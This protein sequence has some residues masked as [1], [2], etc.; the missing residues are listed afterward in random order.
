M[1]NC[2]VRKHT[3]MHCLEIGNGF[4]V[5]GSGDL[6]EGKNTTRENTSGMHK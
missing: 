3:S 4:Q 6:I 1:K 2:D 5:L